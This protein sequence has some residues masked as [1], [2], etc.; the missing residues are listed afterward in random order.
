M[1]RYSSLNTALR[2]PIQPARVSDTKRGYVYKCIAYRSI[3][4]GGPLRFTRWRLAKRTDDMRD[5]FYVAR[6]HGWEPMALITWK[7][8]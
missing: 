4:V 5:Y 3:L 1:S 2:P 7:A 6:N 8:D